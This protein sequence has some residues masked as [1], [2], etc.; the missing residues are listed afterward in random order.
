MKLQVGIFSEENILNGK[1][2]TDTKLHLKEM[3]V[4]KLRGWMMNEL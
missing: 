4:K 3:G 1:K 2:K